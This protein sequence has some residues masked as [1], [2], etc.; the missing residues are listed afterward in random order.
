ME[1]VNCTACQE[2]I[3]GLEMRRI[4]Y[5]SD[6]HLVNLKRKVSGMGPLTD[7]EF[8]ARLK[9]LEES[10]ASA[11]GKKRSNR[12]KSVC[13]VCHKT[14]SSPK[15]LENHEQSRRHLDAVR[16]R[17]ASM[18]DLSEADDWTP[19]PSGEESHPDATATSESDAPS[20]SFNDTHGDIDAELKARLQNWQEEGSDRRCPFDGQEFPST[21]EAL[22]YMSKTFDFFVPY[23]ERLID[24]PGMLRYIGQKIC[25]GFA[26]LAC[27]KGFAS[28]LD[29]RRHMIDI[30]H[31]RVTSDE[32][33]FNEEFAEFYD[34][35]QDEGEGW[36]E[37]D[38]KDKEDL[39]AGTLIE[40]NEAD[41]DVQKPIGKL[42]VNGTDDG[43]AEVYGIVIGDKM[44][45][46][47]SFNRFYK[48]KNTRMTDVR[49]SVVASR[50]A[51]KELQLLN[52]GK[53]AM[54]RDG[55]V[56]KAQKHAYHKQQRFELMIG[57]QN[58]YVRKSRFKQSMAVFNSGYRA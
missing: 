43:E 55:K 25:I 54:F 5:R 16:H 34:W 57:H 45:G 14:F 10:K 58:Y 7:A 26:C 53:P 33:A 48:Q 11:A 21:K 30:G 40:T 19:A 37:V 12:E 9:L 15:A 50:N 56:A 28:V 46:H 8:Q 23:A 35:G 44:V 29:A 6:I 47:R 38:E 36:E 13:H 41:A 52:L 18:S 24:P 51:T 31:C 4:H 39:K 32:E 22:A 42:D 2:Q 27:D 1:T 3:I 20:W 17:H 49:D